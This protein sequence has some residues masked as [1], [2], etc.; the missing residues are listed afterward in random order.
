MARAT[1]AM[2]GDME[3]DEDPVITARCEHGPVKLRR[4]GRCTLMGTLS[5]AYTIVSTCTC[6]GKHP[7]LSPGWGDQTATVP[8]CSGEPAVPGAPLVAAE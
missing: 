2:C 4:T 8:L 7:R 1:L 3:V 5:E 6:N